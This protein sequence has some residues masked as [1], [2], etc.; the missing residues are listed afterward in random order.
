MKVA[1]RSI[2][3]EAWGQFVM[4]SGTFV[5]PRLCAGSWDAAR[6]SQLLEVLTLAKARATSCW[7][8]STATEPR[9]PW[10]IVLTWAGGGTT[11][12]TTKM[13][14]LS[15]QVLS[16]FLFSK[17]FCYKLHSIYLCQ[18]VGMQKFF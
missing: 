4:I 13:L 6:P 8:M 15:V 11:V 3:E 18:H 17:Y 1:L 16:T 10:S 5:M 12:P 2:T 14:V 9:S 7:T